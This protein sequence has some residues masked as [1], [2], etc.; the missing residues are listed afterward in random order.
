M[1]FD[2]KQMQLYNAAV[3]LVRIPKDIDYVRFTETRKIIKGK[4]SLNF[5]QRLVASLRKPEQNSQIIDQ[6]NSQEIDLDFEFGID[7]FGH[8]YMK[9]KIQID[10]ELTCQRCML[11]MNYPIDIAIDVAFIQNTDEEDEILGLY[12]PFYIEDKSEPIDFHAFIEDEILLALPLIAKHDDICVDLEQF[13][14]DI[15]ARFVEQEEKKVNPFDVLK[16][17][18][19][20]VLKDMK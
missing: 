19:K 4:L 18:K 10:V 13:N 7:Q 17:M 9:G 1:Y 8:R 20:D 3:M 11:G 16:D 2:N 14:N 15:D 12:E 6:R 5:C